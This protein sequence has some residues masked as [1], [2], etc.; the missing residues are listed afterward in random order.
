MALQFSAYLE[1]LSAQ[2]VLFHGQ[3][4]VRKKV[5]KCRSQVEVMVK[6]STAGLTSDS[7]GHLRQLQAA[8]VVGVEYLKLR[9]KESRLSIFRL[10]GIDL[11]ENLSS[12]SCRCTRSACPRSRR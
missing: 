2:E 4:P 8:V 7:L 5:L 1:D 10:V 11:F 9:G 12:P 3:Q 6:A